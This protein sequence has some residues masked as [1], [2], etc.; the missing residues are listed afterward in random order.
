MLNRNNYVVILPHIYVCYFSVTAAPVVGIRNCC[1]KS[2]SPV[3][4][5]QA[6][7][8][9]EPCPS[10]RGQHRAATFTIFQF[11]LRKC[12]TFHAPNW[13]LFFFNFICRANYLIF[14][15]KINL[16]RR[17]SSS[18][19]VCW[20]ALPFQSVLISNVN[21]QQKIRICTF[22]NVF[23]ADFQLFILFYI[24]GLAQFPFTFL[25]RIN[26]DATLCETE[27]NKL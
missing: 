18:Q 5:V 27:I 14:G 22:I 3:V 8:V 23:F 6:S 2:A 17:T 21:G 10:K 19:F 4:I 12:D 24:R 25:I 11:F 26:S 7:R 16:F 9:R 13:Q 15:G 1:V 20:L